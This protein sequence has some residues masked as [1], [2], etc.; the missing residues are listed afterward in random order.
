MR[1]RNPSESPIRRTL[2]ALAFGAGLS[3][4]WAADPRATAAAV[5]DDPGAIR[6]LLAA[7][8][9]TTLS[10]QMNGTLAD[11]QA[12]LGQ[13]VAKN[14]LLA[15]FICTETQARAKVAGAELN[16]A[17]QNLEAKRNLQKL[18]AAGDLEVLNATTEVEKA[19]G[20]LT[21]ARTQVGYCQVRAPFSGRV[22]KVLAKPHQTVSAGTPLFDLVSDGPLKVRLNVPSTLLARLKPGTPVAVSIHETGKTYPAKVSAINARVDAVAQTVELEARLDNEHPELIPGMSGIAR[23]PGQ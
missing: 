10:S 17:R 5:A 21:L 15:Q 7:Q 2:I 19:D 20:A 22:A 11:M 9:E 6:V 23:F 18:N 8:L 16:L 3:C 4:A 12:V 14:A 13:K 1:L